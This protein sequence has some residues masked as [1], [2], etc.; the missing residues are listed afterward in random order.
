[1]NAKMNAKMNDKMNAKM[2]DKMNAKM[3]AKMKADMNAKSMP[4]SQ[5]TF[6]Q[7]NIRRRAPYKI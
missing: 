3:N 6:S 5:F 7:Q 4:V 2:N 1:M